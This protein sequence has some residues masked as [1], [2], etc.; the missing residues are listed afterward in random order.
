MNFLLIQ[1]LVA[2]PDQLIK[3]RGQL[4]LVGVDKSFEETRKWLADK[5]EKEIKVDSVTGKLER[6][7]V[8]PYLPHKDNE[9][10]YVCIY[11]TRD[12]NTVLFHTEGGIN[13]GDIDSKA[14]RENID[15]NDSLTLEQALS[16]V[17][18]APSNTQK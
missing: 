13:I 7:I 8:E 6:F 18:S 10:Y 3:R 12:G 5:M 2:K 4:G 17:T 14:Y 1:S 9:E 16:L 15:I 11:A